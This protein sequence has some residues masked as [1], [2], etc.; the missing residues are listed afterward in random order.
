[1]SVDESI[2]IVLTARAAVY[3]ILQNL[4]GNEPHIDALG[5]LSSPAVQEVFSLFT[6]GEDCSKATFDVL[7]SA[8]EDG[9][10]N[11]GAFVSKLTD[12]F[13][14]L[15][16]GPGKTEAD[17]WES[18]HISKENSL[19]Q[20]STLEVRKAY[21]ASGLIPQSYPHVAD[22]HIALELDFMARLAE[23]AEDAWRTNALER[24]CHSLDASKE[25][26][27]KHLLVWT[28]S[29]VKGLA[30]AKHAQF[31]DKVGHVLEAFL[32][33]DRSALDEVDVLLG[34]S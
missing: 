30:Q 3:R 13:T 31:Y 9:L 8:A 33:I 29:F 24:V 6:F 20:S 11:G 32:P 1:M 5:Q 15:F 21:V 10:Q 26:L 34:S 22:D 4:L 12:D 25:F 19:F 17:P 18:L 2:E 14:R 23:R 16:V 27:D 7:F 28:P